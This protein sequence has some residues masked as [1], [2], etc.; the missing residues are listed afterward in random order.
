[1]AG[2]GRFHF[3]LGVALLGVTAGLAGCAEGGRQTGGTNGFPNADSGDDPPPLLDASDPEPTP[4]ASVPDAAPDAGGGDAR[5]K[6]TV[7]SGSVFTK[8]VNGDNWDFGAAP[9]DV[10]VTI[11]Y[12]FNAKTVM[13]SVQDS[14]MPMWDEVLFTD[15]TLD[16][17]S[18]INVQVEDLDDDELLPSEA[19]KIGRCSFDW[20]PVWLNGPTTLSCPRQPNE[21]DQSGFGIYVRFEE[22]PGD[23]VPAI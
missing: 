8:K 14:F 23:T 20:N 11:T 3:A 2:A 13:T 4:D 7:I 18:V 12:A 17:L 22:V 10:V 6:L 16:E 21:P 5:I 19:D 1:M 15:A 9:P